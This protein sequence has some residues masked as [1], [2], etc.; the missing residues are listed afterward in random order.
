M[1]VVRAMYIL[2]YSNIQKLARL[3]HMPLEPYH[4]P[5]SLVKLAHRINSFVKAGDK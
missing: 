3:A 2:M 5:K 4:S 1:H